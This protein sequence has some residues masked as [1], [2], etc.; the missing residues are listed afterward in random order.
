MDDVK[1]LGAELPIPG[2]MQRGRRLAR[3]TVVGARH[4][5]PVT[6]RA[7]VRRRKEGA[8][9]AAAMRRT[10]EELGATYVKFG[11]FIASAPAIVGEDVAREFRA[12]L[13]KGPAL[14]F[15][16]VRALVEQDTGRPLEQTFRRFERQPIAAAS[17]AVVHDAELMD[18]RRVAVKVLRPAMRA[19]VAADLGV[20]SPMARFMT[21]QGSEGAAAILNYLIG[22]R[23]QIREELDLRNE[24]G[25]MARFRR[26]TSRRCFGAAGSKSCCC[27]NVSCSARSNCR[28]GRRTF[29]T[30]SCARRST[31]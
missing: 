26:P 16:I 28:R 4:V 15:A 24:M 13:D 17:L 2:M 18:G 20:L 5:A 23:V 21:M 19:T 14:D 25:S 22:L 12:C 9:L 27:P 29:S 11:Q 7:L 30:A 31:G 10:C 8:T 3:T 1:P 6:A